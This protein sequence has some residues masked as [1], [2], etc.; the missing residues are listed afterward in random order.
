MNE[1]MVVLGTVY[2]LKWSSIAVLLYFFFFELDKWMKMTIS[3][4]DYPNWYGKKTT[5]TE[6]NHDCFRFVTKTALL[7]RNI[8]CYFLN[9]PIKA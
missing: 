6:E 4:F 3:L 8:T 9:Q 2:F 7:Y 1:W 5:I